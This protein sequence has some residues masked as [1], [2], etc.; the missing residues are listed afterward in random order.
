MVL[1]KYD[2]FTPQYTRCFMR[3]TDITEELYE[4]PHPDSP[5]KISLL[6]LSKYEA[7]KAVNSQQYVYH[8]DPTT[9]RTIGIPVEMIQGAEMEFRKNQ[10]EENRRR[11]ALVSAKTVVWP[12]VFLNGVEYSVML[13]TR[14]RE[15]FDR[16]RKGF[17]YIHT[18]KYALF[19][20]H[21]K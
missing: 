4:L 2:R 18:G 17:K 19:L 5:A 3:Y 16:R 8:T 13:R 6:P 20:K 1:N 12:R 15:E 14:Y 7:S 11:T 21:G 10:D 9:A